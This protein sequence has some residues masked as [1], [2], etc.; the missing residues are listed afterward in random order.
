[1]LAIDYDNEGEREAGGGEDS[2]EEH[3]H[4]PRDGRLHHWRLQWEGF[5]PGDE[6][7]DCGD[8]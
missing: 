6:D 8:R 7:D 2:P 3:D 4:P 1:M 5:H